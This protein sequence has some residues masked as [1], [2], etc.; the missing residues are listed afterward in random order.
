MANDN[1]TIG[2]GE[3]SNTTI[4]ASD[5][6]QMLVDSFGSKKK[7]KVMESKAANKVNVPPPFESKLLNI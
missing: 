2:G 7:Q 6:V 5:R 1:M 3:N 4:S